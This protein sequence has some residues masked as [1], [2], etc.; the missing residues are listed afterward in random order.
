MIFETEYDVF[1]SFAEEDLVFV[2]TKLKTPLIEMGYKVCWH[3]D[4]F[5]P[6]YP[7]VENI[8]R[9]IY[10]SG[11]M[12]AA[13]SNS[14]LKS[15]FCQRELEIASRKL[16]QSSKNFY[17]IPVILEPGCKLP[18]DVFS[19]TYIRSDD[20]MLLSKVAST[21]GMPMYVIV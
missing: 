21:L 3:H 20:S 16:Q 9:S 7:V 18:S 12:I 10:K 4:A 6:G 17:L 14:F 1:L 8:E 5:I 11:C 13:L 15:E 2:E 19:I